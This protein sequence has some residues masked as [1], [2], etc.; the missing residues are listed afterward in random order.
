MDILARVMKLAADVPDA[1]GRES[2]W[3]ADKLHCGVQVVT[4]WKTRGVPLDRLP[5]LADILGCSV[6]HLLGRDDRTWP[7]HD[8][9]FKRFDRLSERH[10][11][12]VERAML[13]EIE[14]IEA[15]AGKQAA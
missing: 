13:I 4:N 9:P 14:R 1:A 6:D 8:V 7:F 10:K 2:Q 11:G 12:Q 5:A 15:A 3:L